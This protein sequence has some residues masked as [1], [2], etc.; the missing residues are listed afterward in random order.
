[1]TEHAERLAALRAEPSTDAPGDP[2]RLARIG[3]TRGEMMAQGAA[4]AATLSAEAVAVAE[5]A[6]VLKQRRV[7]RVVIAGCGDSWHVG[8]LVRPAL[9]RCFGVTVE[10]AQAFDFAY[11]AAA[12][13][14]PGT[15]VFGLS[16]GGNTPAV[17]A[18]LATARA[19]GAFAVG[20][21]NTANAPVL[22]DYD[23]G[24]LVHATRRGWP[25]Q[26]STAAAA[27]LLA[28][29]AAFADAAGL[30]DAL[31]TLPAL[32]DATIAVTEAPMARV[33]K[34][35]AGA[36][37][38]FLT[39]AGPWL[40]AAAIGAAKLRELSPIHAHAIA[41][42]E[43]HHY[44]LP[45][46]GDYLVILAADAAS[47]ERAFDTALVAHAM[48]ARTLALLQVPDPALAALVEAA[49]VLPESPPDT[50]PIVAC[51]PLHLF[52]GHFALARDALGLG[53][54]GVWQ[55]APA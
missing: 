10:A 38:I 37:E 53:T 19:R 36:R 29:G 44:R 51:L 21:S 18:A 14:G 25:T 12:H 34:D 42:E 16:S 48:G 52:A 33:A 6:R 2:A 24:L 3:R 5:L 26:S 39:G 45:K 20:V 11:Y 15:L 27:L 30:T 40:G 23:A 1:M 50:R 55:G 46:Q 32:T 17:M 7:D 13:T 47:R 41:L 28:L 22:R 8:A 31:R 9:E 54:Q 4:I 35:W 49:I 43:M